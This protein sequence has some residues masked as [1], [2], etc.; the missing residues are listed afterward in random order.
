MVRQS[1][2]R[3]TQGERSFQHQTCLYIRF[4]LSFGFHFFNPKATGGEEDSQA[5]V[6]TFYENKYLYSGTCCALPRAGMRDHTLRGATSGPWATLPRSPL[7][8]GSDPDLW[9]SIVLQGTI[10]HPAKSSHGSKKG[11][12]TL[13][14]IL[15]KQR[16]GFMHITLGIKNKGKQENTRDRKFFASRLHV[17]RDS[18]R[19]FAFPG[20][21][22]S[23]LMLY[24][25]HLELQLSLL[26]YKIW[27]CWDG[28]KPS[29]MGSA[30]TN[31]LA[32]P[33]LP[34]RPAGW[35]E[36]KN[37]ISQKTQWF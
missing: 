24:V 20:G 26:F 6:K 23:S 4:S 34:A 16:S 35:P 36:R 32:L 5:S 8:C 19:E 2:P 7:K 1:Y 14:G 29:S 27:K 13:K 3:G 15:G 21:F 37:S 22:T 30:P 31:T 17:Y 12:E 9:G 33:A 28:Q 25:K 18:L 11:F 10:T